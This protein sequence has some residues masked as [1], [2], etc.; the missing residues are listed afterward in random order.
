[1]KRKNIASDNYIIPENLH[2]KMED[3]SRENIIYR[4]IK[5]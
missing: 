3:D 5:G 4:A 1:M 2:S